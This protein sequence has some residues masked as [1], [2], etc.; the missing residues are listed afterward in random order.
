[1]ARHGFGSGGYK[2]FARPLPDLVAALRRAFYERL[3][4][5]A[6]AWGRRSGR[7]A[8]WPADHD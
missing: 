7:T 3:A 5:I 6:N 4:P 2:Y 1:M 8:D